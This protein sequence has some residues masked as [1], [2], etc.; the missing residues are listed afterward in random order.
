[1]ADLMSAAGL[2]PNLLAPAAATTAGELARSKAKDVAQ[3]FEAQFLS[4]M[5]QSMFAGLKSDGPFG[6]GEGEEMFRSLQTEAMAKQVAKRGGIG[7]AD[8]VQ[9]EILKMQGLT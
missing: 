4:S 1:M 8:V 5:F 2:T 6:G 7:V 3:K 9:R